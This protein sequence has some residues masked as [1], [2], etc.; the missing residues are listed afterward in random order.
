MHI[1]KNIAVKSKKHKRTKEKKNSLSAKPCNPEPCLPA[2]YLRY[3]ADA[4][5]SAFLSA[6]YDYKSDDVRKP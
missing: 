4:P 3:A 2:K 6:V 1:Y 5:R